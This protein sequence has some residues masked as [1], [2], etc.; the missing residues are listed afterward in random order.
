MIPAAFCP[1]L[2]GSPPPL[3]SPMFSH[4]LPGALLPSS[5]QFSTAAAALA[6]PTA[7]ICRELP[8]SRWSSRH[9]SPECDGRSHSRH[10]VVLQLEQRTCEYWSSVVLSGHQRSSAVLSGPQRSSVVIS[11][12]QWSSM[13]LSGHQYSSVNINAPASS[14]RCRRTWTPSGTCARRL[15]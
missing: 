15:C 6:S 11:G 8:G 2:F 3:I 5:I 7:L 9:G 13:V 10:R 4:S 14:R 1:V 12:P